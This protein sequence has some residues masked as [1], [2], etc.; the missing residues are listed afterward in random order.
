MILIS[1][2]KRKNKKKINIGN[3]ISFVPNYFESPVG[4]EASSGDTPF[5]T[6]GDSSGPVSESEVSSFIINDN[7]IEV[8]MISYENLDENL[9]I[10]QESIKRDTGKKL[11]AI[12]NP[13]EKHMEHFKKYESYYGNYVVLKK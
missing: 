5:A 12:F 1:K 3:G 4:P 11:P 2:R 7:S 13:G 8:D 9:K 6:L 10:L